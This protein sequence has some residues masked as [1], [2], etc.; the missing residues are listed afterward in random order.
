[1]P[2]RRKV[3]LDTDPGIDDILAIMLAHASPEFEFLGITTVAGNVRVD[4]GT[5]NA[6]AA[7]Q[8]IGAESLPVLPSVDA[9]PAH[10]GRCL[11]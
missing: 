9:P 1:M 11:R 8:V 2:N 4:E 10:P 3:I 6:L 5:N 7:R